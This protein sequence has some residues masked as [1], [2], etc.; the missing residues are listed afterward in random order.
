M[1]E[2]QPTAGGDRLT[3]DPACVR[4]GEQRD[5]SR[6]ILGLAQAPEGRL[7]LHRNP[8]FVRQSAAHHLRVSGSGGNGVDTDAHGSHFGGEHSGDLLHR[9]LRAGVCC[10][11]GHHTR[12]HR[13]GDVDDAAFRLGQGR[14]RFAA[15]GEQPG[16][17]E[18]E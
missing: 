17:I 1:L 15:E 10:D 9:R 8:H 11:T 2:H 12:G 4:S 13:R 16:D 14:Q 18:L 3:R 7:A 5:R 6:D